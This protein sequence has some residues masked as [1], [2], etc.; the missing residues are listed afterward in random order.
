MPKSIHIGRTA[1]L[2]TVNP[3]FAFNNNG[4]RGGFVPF[5]FQ[6]IARL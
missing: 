3:T 2:P 6:L 5:F 1:A 4:A